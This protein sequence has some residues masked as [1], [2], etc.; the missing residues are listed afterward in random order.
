MFLIGEFSRIARVSTRQLRHYD[1]IGLFTPV[2]I[3]AETGYRYY[4]AD[5]LPK[6]NRILAL[7]DLGLSLDQITRLLDEDISAEE[8]HGM[9]TLRK[10]QIEQTLRDELERV[11]SIEE[12]I[13]QIET[14]GVLGDEDVVLKSIPQQKFLSVRQMIPT[15]REGFALMYDIHRLLPQRAGRSILGNFGII[16][17]S[18]GFTMEDIDV[19]MGFLLEQPFLDRFKLS[20]GRE[21]TVRTVPAVET[22]A[23]LARVGIYNDSVG[24][25]GALGTWI[26]K[27]DYQIDGA[28]WEVFIQPFQPGMEDKAVVEIQIPVKP[29][30]RD[31]QMS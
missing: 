24:H 9:L 12:R 5:Q 23:T 6:L 27:H 19:E 7:K 26:Q 28:G 16:F 30:S 21:M 14:E 10:A 8:M 2:K 11:R 13:W 18:E 3:D 31:L 17:H 1:E 22:M 4:S 15:V 20:D 29:I 25:Y